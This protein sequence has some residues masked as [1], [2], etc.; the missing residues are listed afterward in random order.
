MT[1]A[2][3]KIKDK[4]KNASTR[5]QKTRQQKT[6]TRPPK[7]EVLFSGDFLF[8]ADPKKTFAKLA[9]RQ[10][11]QPLDGIREL[12]ANAIDSYVGTNDDIRIDIK[13]GKDYLEIT[14]YGLGLD[15]YRMELLRTLG[16]TDKTP[17]RNYIGRFGIGFASLFHPDLG[18]HKVT[19]DT[20]DG[21]N[22]RKLTFT[23]QNGNTSLIIADINTPRERGTTIRVKTKRRLDTRADYYIRAS[24]RHLPYN[25]THNGKP[26]EKITHDAKPNET[27]KIRAHN[28]NGYLAYT[29]HAGYAEA[30]ILSHHFEVAGVY[31]PHIL[32][33]DEWMHVQRAAGI[34]NADNLELVISRN[35]LIQDE[36]YLRVVERIKQASRELLDKLITSYEQEPTEDVRLLLARKL[37]LAAIHARKLSDTRQQDKTI[38]RLLKLPVLKVFGRTA[39]A[40]LDELLTE[41]Q[42]HGCILAAE[43]EKDLEP[44]RQS[45]YSAPALH[46][47]KGFIDNRENIT[48]VLIEDVLSGYNVGHIAAWQRDR[49]KKLGIYDP[50]KLIHKSTPV[51][52]TQLTPDQTQ[53]LNTIKDIMTSPP[54]AQVLE[55]YA[56]PKNPD[57]HYGTYHCIWDQTSILASYNPSTRQV[58]L[59]IERDD[60]QTFAQTTDKLRAATLFIPLMA[61]ELTHDELSEHTEEFYIKK[62]HLER[63]LKYAVM[64]YLER[65]DDGL[66]EK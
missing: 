21:K 23:T 33:K 42:K 16:L 36:N 18:V 32:T 14:D 43:D 25:V 13:T 10:F 60:I 63:D 15:D 20:S 35:Q 22:H 29:P 9:A 2:A 51:P 8:T 34:I 3:K 27:V 52:N 40:S 55:R 7:K 6:N 19:V 24:T 65:K 56:L 49:L 66:V 4:T 48:I 59:N 30:T 64:Q 26:I 1:M 12:I 38:N 45:G 31:L 11:D 28:I 46:I 50:F 53:F 39:P 62:G 47:E 58:T 37:Y 44:Y 17:G 57:I 5:Q 41:K 61:H 54:V